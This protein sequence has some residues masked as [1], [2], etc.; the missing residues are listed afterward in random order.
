MSFLGMA[1][2]SPASIYEPG[3]A[4]APEAH[5]KDTTATAYPSSASSSSNPS[6][7]AIPSHPPRS[8]LEKIETAALQ[9]RSDLEKLETNASALYNSIPLW[10]KCIVVFV[11]SWSTLAACFSSTSLLSASQEI[12]VDL[13]TSTAVVNLSTGGL[14]LAMGLSSFIWSPL[15]AIFGR[16]LA[17]NA[18]LAVLFAFTIGGAVAPN[19]P[20]FVTMRVLSGLQ[21]CFFHVAGQTILA[22]YFPPTQ[23]GTATGFFL[24]GTVLGPPMGPLVAG[25]MVT[26]ASWRSILWLQVAMIGIG[27]VLALFFIP[28]SPIDRGVGKMNLTGWHAVKQFSPLPVF[29]VMS[30]PN[31]I[32]TV[33]GCA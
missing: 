27:F 21:G 25:I 16:R 12:A 7:T 14:L 4:M 10:R 2:W 6:T 26:Y 32:F 31:I 1:P 5:T 9:G 23:R 3:L 8:N 17:Y 24:A 30:Y 11:T 18:C 22:E 20:V 19:M 28:L 13:H 15:S 33:S 29:R